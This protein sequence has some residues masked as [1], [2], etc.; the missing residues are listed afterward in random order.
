M[1]KQHSWVDRMGLHDLHQLMDLDE[2]DIL[3]GYRA[4]LRGEEEPDLKETLGFWHGWRNGAT[5]AGFRM[6]DAS[7]LNMARQMQQL[8]ERSG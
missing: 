2:M 5:D 3:Y 4:G 6:P 1:D 8:T 7:Q